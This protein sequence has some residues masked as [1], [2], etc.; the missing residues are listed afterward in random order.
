MVNYKIGCNFDDQ[1]IDKV[2][3][4]NSKYENK[5]NEF[6]G[7]NRSLSFLI[8]RPNFR[9]HDI[10]SIEL[11]R[12]VKRCNENNIEFAYTLNSLYAGSKEKIEREKENINDFIKFLE[13]IGI[14]RFIVSNPIVAELIKKV[15]KLPLEISTIAHIDTVSQ[16]KYWKENYNV[17]KVCVNVLKNR[18]IKFL[19][20]AN[21]YC[22]ENN[23]KL[24]LIVNEFCGV[25]GEKYATHCVYRDSCYLCH[26][27]NVTKQDAELLDGYPMQF[28]INSRDSDDA[29]WLKLRFI[30]PEDIKLYKEIGINDFKITGRTG[31]TEYLTKVAEAYLSESFDGNL[32]ELWKPL[33]TIYSDQKESEFNY[34]ANIPNKKL[35]G[36]LEYWFKNINHECANEDCGVTCNYCNTFY[37]QK[38]VK[39]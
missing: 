34:Q 21:K 26:A 38:I 35:D 16:I 25:G 37:K 7:S 5:I 8:A 1:L 15:S 17:D 11:I 29:C 33:E 13:D 28:C 6:Y 18:S 31:T 4:L 39:Q 3:D 24:D 19:M 22:V 23:V 12:Y 36:F 20:N 10:D 27:E 2:I 30:R 32:L 14:K 9:L